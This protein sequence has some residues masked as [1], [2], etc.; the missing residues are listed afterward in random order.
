[1]GETLPEELD[2]LAAFV[3]RLLTALGTEAIDRALRNTGNNRDRLEEVL[4]D[5]ARSAS[6]DDADIVAKY[7]TD[8]GVAVDPAVIINESPIPAWRNYQAVVT[9]DL[10]MWGKTVEILQNWEPEKRDDAGLTGRVVAVAAEHREI[11]PLGLGFF[12]TTGYAIPLADGFESIARELGVAVRRS[13]VRSAIQTRSEELTAYSYEL[14]RRAKRDPSWSA[15]RPASVHPV[16]TAAAL[17]DGF[18]EA[19]EHFDDGGELGEGEGHAA[20][21]AGLVLQLCD[22]VARES[23]EEGGLA[24]QLASIDITNLNVPMPGASAQ[25]YGAA[26]GAALEADKFSLHS[27]T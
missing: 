24:A 13:D 17:R 19:L 21:A 23:G 9:V 22:A 7:L 12:G 27:H 4:T 16:E 20:T 10:E 8:H 3:G 11:L 15:V 5:A 18:R 6:K 1:V 14:V 26:H 25:L 2:G